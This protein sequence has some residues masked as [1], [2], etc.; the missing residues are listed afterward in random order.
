MKKLL[1]KIRTI[2]DFD[3][4]VGKLA[5]RLM[6]EQP[7]SELPMFDGFAIGILATKRYCFVDLLFSEQTGRY[8]DDTLRQIELASMWLTQNEKKLLEIW[9]E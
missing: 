1:K 6:A 7:I 3:R 8:K 5:K 9:E 2:E 4:L